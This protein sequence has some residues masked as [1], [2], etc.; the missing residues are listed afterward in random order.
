MTVDYELNESHMLRYS[1]NLSHKELK[2]SYRTYVEPVRTSFTGAY[3]IMQ[4]QFNNN[5]KQ[6][7]AP[8]YLRNL[9]LFSIMK[10]TSITIEKGTE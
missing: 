1:P 9:L 7:R 2:P 4:N 5:A 8:R 3:G 10:G 6:T